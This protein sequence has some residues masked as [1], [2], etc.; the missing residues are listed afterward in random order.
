MSG[1]AYPGLLPDQANDRNLAPVQALHK[2]W[3]GAQGGG[4]NW[5]PVYLYR[6]AGT[7]NFAARVHDTDLQAAL[8]DLQ[9]ALAAGSLVARS[10]VTGV[11]TAVLAGVSTF[12]TDWID[13]SAWRSAW[14]WILNT[15]ANATASTQVYYAPAVVPGAW[16]NGYSMAVPVL[17]GQTIW[18][19]S[20]GGGLDWSVNPCL[21][22]A[23]AMRVAVTGGANPTTCTARV[24]LGR[25]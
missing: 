13:V 21:E 25:A 8:V 18:W 15:G 7:G 22:G 10:V 2:V 4:R 1:E 24:V 5:Q 20:R 9:A 11:N 16:Y 23:V 3:D 17:G 6:E 12:L 19:A 14:V